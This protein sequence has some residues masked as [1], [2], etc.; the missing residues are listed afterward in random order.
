VII[1]YI[2]IV[3]ISVFIVYILIE[4]STNIANESKCMLALCFRLIKEEDLYNLKR[5]LPSDYFATPC[6]K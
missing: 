4:G 2:L 1:Y 6:P 5:G 3:I